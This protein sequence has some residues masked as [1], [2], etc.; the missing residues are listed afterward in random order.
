MYVGFVIGGTVRYALGETD[1]PVELVCRTQALAVGVQDEPVVLLFVRK[2]DDAIDERAR[3]PEL[4]VRRIDVEPLEHARRCIE[5][6]D[7]L[8]PWR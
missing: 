2:R 6:G 5:A 3:D 7:G 1:R 8:L 4:P